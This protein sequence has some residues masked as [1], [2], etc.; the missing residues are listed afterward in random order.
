M[1]HHQEGTPM[2]PLTIL[3]VGLAAALLCESVALALCLRDRA[4]WRRTAQTQAARAHHDNLDIRRAQ[5]AAATA[6]LVAVDLLKQR[7]DSQ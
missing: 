1:A 2:E 7:K 5:S 3:S 6:E 4:A